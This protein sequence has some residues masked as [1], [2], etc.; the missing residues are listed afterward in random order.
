MIFVV[1]GANARHS[2]EKGEKQQQYYHY[3]NKDAALYKQLTDTVVEFSSDERL[4]ESCHPFNTQ[5]NGAMNMLV[6][7]HAPKS[8]TE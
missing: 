7:K 6:M 1:L 3:V 2:P 5:T 8:K 4:L